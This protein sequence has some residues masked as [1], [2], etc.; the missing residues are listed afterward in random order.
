M[1]RPFRGLIALA[2]AFAVI[3][4]IAGLII[5][6]LRGVDGGTQATLLVGQ[7]P[8]VGV[9]SGLFAFGLAGLAAAIGSRAAGLNIGLGCAGLVLS[10]AAWLSGRL[11]EIVAVSRQSPLSALVLEGLLVALMLGGIVWL[12]R[13][14][15]SDDPDPETEVGA[16]AIVVA[17]TA[18]VAISATAAWVVAIEPLK[19]QTIGAAFAAG[20]VGAATARLVFLRLPGWTAVCIPAVLVVLGPLATQVLAGDVV[21]AVFERSLFR[22][23]WLMPMDWAAGTLLGIPIGLAW[24]D[25]V[26][27]QQIDRADPST[28]SI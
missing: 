20:L 23:G 9:I 1:P 11:D 19:G 13:R 3:G 10:W 26:V 16:S 22:L 25:G 6:S 17:L 5:G 8:I 27:Q 4:P 24:T 15:S 14:F 18:G 21:D 2:V 28:P 12:V 7:S